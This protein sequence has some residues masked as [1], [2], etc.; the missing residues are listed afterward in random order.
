MYH[1]I[2]L[3]N[4][5]VSFTD[6][7]KGTP[8]VLLHGYIEALNVWE[9]IAKKLFENFRVITIDLPGH[10]NSPV[11]DKIHTMEFMADYVNEILTHLYINKCVMIGHSMGGYVTME[12]LSKYPEK[13]TGF[14]LF[15]S[16]P[17]PDSEEKK[18]IRD[19]LIN[20]IKQGKKVQLAKEHVE[21][22]FAPEN[23][24][25]F[26]QEIGFLKIIAINTSDEGTIAALEG[27]KIRKNHSQT[28]SNTP[29]PGLWIFGEKDNFIS[30][31]A[32]DLLKVPENIKIE[33]LKNSGH[34]GFIEEK[35]KSLKI[36]KDFINITNASG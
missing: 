22:T 3:N 35:E 11:F 2:T 10:G 36:L 7:G 26:V 14:S 9:D 28:L 17:F 25:K 6:E 21:K 33:I 27:M 23:L 20:A 31:K 1:N 34:Q 12:F 13:L 29:I 24:S 8:I 16:T 32:K 30:T 5:Q 15:H 4:K 19:R 18:Q